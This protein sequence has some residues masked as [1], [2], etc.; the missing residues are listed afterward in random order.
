MSVCYFLMIPLSL[1]R[2]I[3]VSIPHN[4]IRTVSIP[5]LFPAGILTTSKMYVL[6]KPVL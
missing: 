4:L 6:Y 1:E 3:L 2:E 5:Q